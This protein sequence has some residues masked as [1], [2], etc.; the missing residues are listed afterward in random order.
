[1][2]VTTFDTLKFVRRLEGVGVPSEQAEAQAEVLTEAFTVN[3][4]AL[5]T[6]E[7]LSAEFAERFAAAKTH[8]DNQFAE[9]KASLKL[10]F[11]IQG[12]ITLVSVVP[13]LQNALGS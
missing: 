12:L 2:G 6:K 10:L 7:Y 5:V 9:V 8:T 1:M 3:L 11:W 4:E 13:I